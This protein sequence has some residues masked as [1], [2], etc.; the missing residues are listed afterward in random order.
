MTLTNKM[1]DAVQAATKATVDAANAFAQNAELVNQ[2]IANSTKQAQT[3]LSRIP[4]INDGYNMQISVIQSTQAAQIKAI[5][6]TAQKLLDDAYDRNNIQRV[7][8]E[9][10][11]GDVNAK[12]VTPS[13]EAVGAVVGHAKKNF[14]SIT[15]R[16]MGKANS[17]CPPRSK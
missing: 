8:V 17:I 1:S 4:A 11:M 10:V 3:V 6:E 5:K 15:D 13:L 14:F 12:V 2:D 7:S 16:I 9:S